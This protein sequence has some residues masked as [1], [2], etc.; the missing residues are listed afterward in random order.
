[1]RAEHWF[2]LNSFGFVVKRVLRYVKLIP[3]VKN[4]ESIAFQ[5]RRTFYASAKGRHKTVIALFWLGIV[6]LAGTC[7]CVFFKSCTLSDEGQGVVC[8]G[9]LRH[10]RT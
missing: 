4:W 5:P 6:P 3:S 7:I 2:E 8:G 10:K 9:P 1:M